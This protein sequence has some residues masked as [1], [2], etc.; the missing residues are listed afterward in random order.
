MITLG[1][2]FHNAPPNPNEPPVQGPPCATTKK[3]TGVPSPAYQP[4]KIISQIMAPL[5]DANYYVCTIASL[6]IRNIDAV[7]T[8]LGHV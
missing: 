3:P 4:T 7:I 8:G 5:S 1:I 6:P 2:F